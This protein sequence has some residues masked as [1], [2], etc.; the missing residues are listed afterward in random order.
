MVLKDGDASQISSRPSKG[1]Y[2]KLPGEIPS[3]LSEEYQEDYKKWGS[4][5]QGRRK[6]DV[7]AKPTLFYRKLPKPWF[8]TGKEEQ[9]QK[10]PMQFNGVKEKDRMN[11]SFLYV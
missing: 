9:V 8:K 3:T 5:W 4:I 6:R 2:I 10:V 7:R 11:D 1:K